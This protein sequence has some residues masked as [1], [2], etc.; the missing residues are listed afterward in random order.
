MLGGE[1]RVSR[2][3]MMPAL[4][5]LLKETEIC[6]MRQIATGGCPNFTTDGWQ[7]KKGDHSLTVT[8][9]WLSETFEMVSVVL[10]A[11]PIPDRST[12]EVIATLITQRIEK[13]NLTT[14]QLSNGCIDQGANYQKALRQRLRVNVLDCICHLLNHVMEDVGEAVFQ[15]CTAWAHRLVDCLKN[16]LIPRL[17][18]ETVQ[19]TRNRPV[20]HLKRSVKPRWAYNIPVFQRII[21]VWEDL[22][23]AAVTCQP[24]REIWFGNPGKWKLQAIIDV[25]THVSVL[26]TRF[27]PQSKSVIGETFPALMELYRFAKQDTPIGPGDLNL[28]KSHLHESL[29]TVL[30]DRF[31][32]D[33]TVPNQW[34]ISSCLD[35]R[36]KDMVFVAQNLPTP[37]DRSMP[38]LIRQTHKN[39][40]SELAAMVA[41]GERVVEV[42]HDQVDLDA[43]DAQIDV[44]AALPQGIGADVIRRHE[45]AHDGHFV[46]MFGARV[47]EEVNRPVVVEETWQQ[48]WEKFRRE[49]QIMVQDDPLRWWNNNKDKFPLV[50]KLARKY[51]AMQV[52]AAASERVWSLAGNV[53]SK[54]RMSLDPETL[55]Q[56]LFIKSNLQR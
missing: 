6:V 7:S 20:K 37:L 35:P 22:E 45:V 21:D 32:F 44:D 38:K 9:H 29:R 33:R 14:S 53:E 19:R 40:Q 46:M 27:Q 52:S 8:L 41:A 3:G 15:D 2:V 23:E 54:K 11:P 50:A 12:N 5:I 26:I 1:D 47:L 28:F 16:S 49:P 4:Q 18:L 13:F 43:L 48:Q 10:G 56:V 51:L 34:L 25:L 55:H 31:H 24:I 39:I 36:F 17:A 42:F 30:R